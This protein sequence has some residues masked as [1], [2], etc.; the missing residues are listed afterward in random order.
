MRSLYLQEISRVVIVQFLP[1]SHC[2]FP[3]QLSLNVFEHVPETM[4]HVSIE[5]LKPSSQSEFDVQT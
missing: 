3:Q 5:Q 1:A 4:S 2:P